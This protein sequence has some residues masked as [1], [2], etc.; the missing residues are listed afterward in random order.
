ML[1]KDHFGQFCQIDCFHLFFLPKTMSLVLFLPSFSLPKT[2]SLETDP[3]DFSLLK[4]H[5]CWDFSPLPVCQI[6]F[7]LWHYCQ[8]FKCSSC[9]VK[10]SCTISKIVGSFV[11]GHSKSSFMVEEERGVLKKQTKT[12]RRRWWSSLSLN[13]L[14]EKRFMIFQATVRVLFDNLFD[15]S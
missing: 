7:L 9:I 5:A 10:L 6:S 12:K 14:C 13:L 15:I 4:L 11:W 1:K 8:S 2:M 3:P